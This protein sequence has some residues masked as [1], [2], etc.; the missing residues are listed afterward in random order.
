MTETF[1]GAGATQPTAR[2]A[3]SS[4]CVSLRARRRHT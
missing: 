4:S 1:R 2:A 3:T